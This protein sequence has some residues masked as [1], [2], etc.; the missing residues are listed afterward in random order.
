MADSKSPATSAHTAQDAGAHQA[1]FPPF[2]AETFPSQLLWFVL[3]F[4]ALYLLMS[5]I[6]LPRVGAIL[7]TR[8]NRIAADLDTA[9]RAQQQAD[10]A[11]KAHEKTLTDARANAR[12]TAQAASVRLAA[13]SDARRK[14][15]EADLNA[16]LAVA[17]KQIAATKAAAM[18]HVSQIA[19]DAAAAIVQQLT[20]RA[21][22]AAVIASAVADLKTG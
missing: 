19:E 12:D 14:S 2:N 5:R 11:G 17:E 8:E 10:A 13:E 21:A 18:G 1:N 22:P 6:A 20:G 16:Q 3:A 7:E 4:G 9:A 15:L